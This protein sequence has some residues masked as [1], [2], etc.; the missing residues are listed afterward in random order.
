MT[1]RVLSAVLGVLAGLG[2]AEVLGWDPGH[3]GAAAIACAIIIVS[4]IVIA[5]ELGR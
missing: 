5:R 3:G 4:A 2:G 1:E